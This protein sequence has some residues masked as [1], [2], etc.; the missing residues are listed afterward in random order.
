LRVDALLDSNV[1]IAMLVE[2]HE[3]HAASLG[4]DYA[5]SKTRFAVSVLYASA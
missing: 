1:L 4:G 3:H 5:E 2:A